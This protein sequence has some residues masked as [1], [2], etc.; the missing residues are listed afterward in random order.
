[1]SKN[2][3]M[4]DSICF[5]SI[6]VPEV[7]GKKNPDEAYTN[8]YQK[9]VAC[10]YEIVRVGDNFSQHFKP[11]LGKDIVYNLLTSMIK[12]SKNCSNVI[13]NILTKDLE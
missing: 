4:L 10:S 3:K 5:E 9:Q 13:K 11:S 12:K 2:V 1:M 6:L 8:K 7:C